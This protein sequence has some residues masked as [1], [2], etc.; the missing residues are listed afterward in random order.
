MDDGWLTLPRRNKLRTLT[1]H[2]TVRLISRER[3]SP[4]DR[5]IVSFYVFQ[6][7]PARVLA[8]LHRLQWTVRS[9]RFLVKVAVSAMQELQDELQQREQDGP[10]SAAC[11]VA[12]S[13][14]VSL[15]EPEGEEETLVVIVDSFLSP[16]RTDDS[17]A[18]ALTIALTADTCRSSCLQHIHQ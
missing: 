6:G 1:P 18:A 5:G 16:Q 11:A 4:A 10:F 8:L 2:G 7:A 17:H 15:S 3:L 12:V 13:A 9:E 14:P